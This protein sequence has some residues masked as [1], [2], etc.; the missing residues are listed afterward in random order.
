MATDPDKPPHGLSSAAY[1]IGNFDGVHLGHQAVL[2]RTLELAHETARPAAVLTFE[3]HPAD[4]FAGRPVVFRITQPATKARIFEEL[5]FDGAVVFRFDSRL[6]AFSAE[7]FVE[8]VLVRRLAVSAVVVGCDFHFGKGRLGDAQF[9]TDAGSRF[10]FEVAIVEKVE[11]GRI[12]GRRVLS[13]TSIRHALENGDV[14]NAATQLGRR[15]TICGTVVSGQKLGRKLGTP[16][17]NI[18]LELGNRL[19]YGVYAVCARVGGKNMPAVASFGIRP[20]VDA[21]PPLLEVHILDFSGDLYGEVICVG[22]VERL[23]GEKKFDSLSALA[24]QME[25]DKREARDIFDRLG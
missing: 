11:G 6:A 3:P 4:H 2:H 12:D 1:A 18:V 16:T 7:E 20:T 19:A 13:S 22:F 25:Q 15:Y 5:G 17:A 14:A 23:R 8:D 24:K 10:G 21:G 9:L